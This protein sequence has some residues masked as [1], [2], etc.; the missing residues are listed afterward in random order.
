MEILNFYYFWENENF[1]IISLKTEIS[2]NDEK[3]LLSDFVLLDS[4]LN[5]TYSV[6]F[7]FKTEVSFKFYK[8]LNVVK[9]FFYFLW[10]KIYLY[11]CLYP[12]DLRTLNRFAWNRCKNKEK[13]STCDIGHSF[14]T[15]V[16][17]FWRCSILLLTEKL[18][19]FENF[20]KK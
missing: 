14:L 4:A 2:K 1:L 8:V 5:Y 11:V 20:V 6:K 18:K 19:F 17:Y 13:K 15:Q 10:F 16:S 9:N 12:N 7:L 3:I